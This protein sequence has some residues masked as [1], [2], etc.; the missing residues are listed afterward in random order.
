M[1]MRD[2]VISKLEEIMNDNL[3][4][5]GRGLET[6]DGDFLDEVEQ[7]NDS[8]DEELLDLYAYTVGPGG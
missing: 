6:Y 3:H 1:S 4:C 8:S 2:I 7:L 5:G